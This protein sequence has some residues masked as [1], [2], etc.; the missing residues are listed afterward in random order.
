[1]R[2]VSHKRRSGRRIIPMPTSISNVPLFMA[3]LTVR[4]TG[5]PRCRM[6][7]SRTS[8][9]SRSKKERHRGW[10]RWATLVVTTTIEFGVKIGFLGGTR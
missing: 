10:I 7:E 6:E 4:F 3:D 5:V 9:R 2:D 1:L 8:D